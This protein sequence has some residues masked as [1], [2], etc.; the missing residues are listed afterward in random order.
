MGGEWRG[1]QKEEENAEG[2][3]VVGEGGLLKEEGGGGEEGLLKDEGGGRARKD[4]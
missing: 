4:G 3:G 2:N 1:R